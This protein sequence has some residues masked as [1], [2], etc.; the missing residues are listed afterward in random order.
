[1]VAS[2][3]VG[4]GGGRQRWRHVNWA[5]V[6]EMLIAW[7]ITLPAAALLAAAVYS[8]VQWLV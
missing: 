6:R 1:V 4:L 7:V 3:V 8:L 5:I 2:S